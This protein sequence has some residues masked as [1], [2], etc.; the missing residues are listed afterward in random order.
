VAF[1]ADRVSE[2]AE[3][4]AESPGHFGQPLRPEHEQDDYEQE[5][6]MGRLEDVPNH[7]SGLG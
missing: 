5:Q 6:Q 4:A 2:V 7:C 3:A 1:T